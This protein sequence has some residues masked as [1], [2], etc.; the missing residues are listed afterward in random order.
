MGRKGKKGEG[1]GSRWEEGEGVTSLAARKTRKTH[2]NLR[3]NPIILSLNINGRLVRLNL[4]QHISRAK[5]LSFFFLPAG[6]T[7]FGHGG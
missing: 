3:H 4:H 5:R 2:D 7:S 1:K 6:Y